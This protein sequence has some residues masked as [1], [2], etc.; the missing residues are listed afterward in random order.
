MSMFGAKRLYLM[1][2]QRLK[3]GGSGGADAPP[4]SQGGFGGACRPPESHIFNISG[5]IFHIPAIFFHI[6]EAASLIL[7]SILRQE[8][9]I[10]TAIYF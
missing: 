9:K 8:D 10:D 7:E 6:S 3:E 4:G 2:R 1:E 5:H